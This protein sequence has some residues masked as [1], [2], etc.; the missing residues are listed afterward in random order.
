MGQGSGVTHCESILAGRSRGTDHESLLLLVR[1]HVSRVGC[2]LSLLLSVLALLLVIPSTVWPQGT[3]SVGSKRFTES[4]I[5]GEIVTQTAAQTGPAQVVHQQGLG[6]TAI[7]HAALKAGAIHV[8]P[9]YRVFALHPNRL[10]RTCRLRAS[11]RS[12]TRSGTTRR[13]ST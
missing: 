9:E 13:A 8:Y 3:L 12:R 2:H 10:P 4:Y 7:L 6:N 1:G 11:W 5:L